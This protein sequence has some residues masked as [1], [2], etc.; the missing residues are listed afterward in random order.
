MRYLRCSRCLYK[1]V[2]EDVQVTI[3]RSDWETMYYGYVVV[4]KRSTTRRGE[5]KGGKKGMLRKRLQ[6]S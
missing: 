2:G 4:V 1:E 5:N 3:V 6:K